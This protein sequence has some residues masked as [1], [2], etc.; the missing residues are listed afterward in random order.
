MFSVC[1]TFYGDYPQLAKRL[2]DSLSCYCCVR[3]F[4]FG[5]NAVS[6]ATRS[7]VEAW[8]LQQHANTPVFLYEEANSKN[9]GKYPLMRQMFTDTR[10]IAPKIMWFDD[11]SYLDETAGS[12]WW[13]KINAVSKSHTQVGVIHTLI[14]RNRQFEVIARQPWYTGEIVNARHRFS[15]A[16]GGWWVADSS[17]LLKWDFPFKALYHNGGDSI[18]GELLRQQRKQ[19]ATFAGG[20]QCHCESCARKGLKTGIP[21]VHINVGGR[22]G[23]RGIGVT[24][25]RYIWADGNPTPPLDHQDFY[26]KVSRYEI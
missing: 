24:G 26:L 20:V 19:I 9:V 16:T 23:R 15:F 10:K 4:R 8:A 7:C 21:V 5:L 12:G 11:D 22:K 13:N 18:L 25:E 1:A 3:D 14:Q 6:E 2:L 17:F